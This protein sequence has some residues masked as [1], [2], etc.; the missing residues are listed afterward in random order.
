MKAY[1][2][3]IGLALVGGLL[4]VGFM[5]FEF[6]SDIWINRIVIMTGII[7]FAQYLW[8]APIYEKG[9]TMLVIGVSIFLFTGR[10]VFGRETT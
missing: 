2:I 4:C 3:G 9:L 7:E 6:F 10:A 5:F 8:K 1:H